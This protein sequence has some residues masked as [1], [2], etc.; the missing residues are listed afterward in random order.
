MASFQ[1]LQKLI[2]TLSAFTEFLSHPITEEKHS[3]IAHLYLV[4]KKSVEIFS[5]T[6]FQNKKIVYYSGLLHDIGKLNP[7]YQILFAQRNQSGAAIDEIE[8]KYEQIHSPLSAWAADKLLSKKL[9]LERNDI[10]KIL[11]LIYGH[12]SKIRNSLGEFPES[13]K[14]KNSKQ[15]M[16]QNLKAFSKQVSSIPDFSNLNWGKCIEK[17]HMPIDFQLELKT[18]KP[19]TFDDFLEMLIAF[20][21]LLQADRGSFSEFKDVKFDL[22][23]D[24]TSQKKNSKLAELRTEFQRQVIKNFEEQEPIVIIEAPTGIGKTKVF[25]DL[26]A[27]YKDDE[28][29][30]RIF[31]FSPLL[32]LT[33]DFENKLEQSIPKKEDLEQI[34]SYNHIFAGS[35][36]EKR[37]IEDGR[38]QQTEWSFPIESFNK[39]FIITTTQ[40]LLMTIFSNKQRDNLK[41]VSFKNSILII[42]EIQVIP[43][44]LLPI[45]KKIL[46]KLNQ[47]LGTRTILVSAT[48]PYELSEIKKVHVNDDTIKRYLHATQK[49]ISY[50]SLD[51]S[52]ISVDRTLIMANTRRKSANLFFQMKQIHHDKKLLYLSTGIRKKDRK[53]ILDNL[54]DSNNFA[55][56]ATQVVEAGVDLSFKSI[57]RETAPLDSLV[58][59]MGRLNREGN[60][61]C[62]QL[63]VYETDGNYKPYSELEFNESCRLIRNIDN[64]IKLYA[65][66]PTYY[67]DINTRNQYNLGLVNEMEKYIEKMD[68][69]NVWSFV[70]RHIFMDDEKDTVFIPDYEEWDEVKRS[71]LTNLPK[72]A[73]KK[74]GALTAS[75]PTGVKIPFDDFDKELLEKNILLPKK[76]QLKEFYWYDDL[77]LDKW[78]LKS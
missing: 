59:V 17:F 12:H 51:L 45:L 11:I 77:G 64:S 16:I 69:E 70:N 10:T 63:V 24:T 56:V 32:A 30:E 20:S 14:L 37:Q 71:L 22:L 48:I 9:G 35:L 46:Q 18:N 39:K 73:Y 21:C 1:N 19:T 8:K 5:T 42:D 15:G 33:D 57:Y 65:T 25:L 3:L 40:R 29:V 76:D 75:F 78:L 58:Q 44:F 26:I 38:Y 62:A 13:Q 68:F 61:E 36:E 28:R 41:L 27:K 72:E 55:L 66:L 52:K 74:Y 43:K 23:I 34:L 60:D 53:K 54:S 7:F 67:K 6:N 2:N 4:A 47:Y 31:Y 49:S 50:Q